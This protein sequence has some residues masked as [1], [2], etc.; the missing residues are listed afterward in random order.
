MLAPG[1]RFDPSSFS[2]KD[3]IKRVKKIYGVITEVMDIAIKDGMV[4][5]R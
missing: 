2:E 1:K 4:Y 5:K 3:V